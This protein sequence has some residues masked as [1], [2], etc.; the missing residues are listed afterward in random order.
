MKQIQGLD[1]FA[2]L[3]IVVDRQVTEMLPYDAA[4]VV[5]A[6]EILPENIKHSISSH[7]RT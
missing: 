6:D 1:L 7:D 4:H 2:P 3:D 5:I